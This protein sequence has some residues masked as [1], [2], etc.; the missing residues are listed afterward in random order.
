MVLNRVMPEWLLDPAVASAAAGVQE[1]AK[2]IADTLATLGDPA[3]AEPARTVRVLRTAAT[4]FEN[5][6][7]VAAREA[8]MRSEL[9]R[10]PDVVATVPTFSDDVHDIEGL[11]RVAERLVAG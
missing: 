5:F 4:S 2:E 8:E 9:S 7:V 3:L 10:L 6:G 1:H 11:W